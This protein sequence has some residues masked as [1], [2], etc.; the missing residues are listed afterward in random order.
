MT[1]SKYQ[2]LALTAFPAAILHG[3]SE[4][5]DGD[6]PDNTPPTEPANVCCVVVVDDSLG[7]GNERNILRCADGVDVT[8]A[9]APS[10]CDDITLE[11]VD[12]S[13]RQILRRFDLEDGLK[14]EDIDEIVIEA[15]LTDA[16]G[17]YY[18]TD[19][20]LFEVIKDFFEHVQV[21]KLEEC[22]LNALPATAWLPASVVNLHLGKNALTEVALVG[23]ALHNLSVLEL[24]DQEGK[25]TGEEEGAKEED[26]GLRSLALSGFAGVSQSEV[27]LTSVDVSGNSIPN[28]AALDFGEAYIVGLDVRNQEDFDNC[29]V[30]EEDDVGDHVVAIPGAA[31]LESLNM[32]E[33]GQ[34]ANLPLYDCEFDADIGGPDEIELLVWVDTVVVAE[35]CIAVLMCCTYDAAEDAVACGGNAVATELA[36]PACANIDANVVL[37]SLGQVTGN[38]WLGS[39]DIDAKLTI[40]AD[41]S[42]ANNDPIVLTG[43]AS[44]IS[45]L[46]ALVTVDMSGCQLQELAPLPFPST[47]T[48]IDLSGNNFINLEDAIPT[49]QEDGDL[50]AIAL[51]LDTQVTAMEICDIDTLN[52]ENAAFATLRALSICGNSD[53]TDFKCDAVDNLE[54]LDLI[55]DVPASPVCLPTTVA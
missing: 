3:C 16:S 25:F 36:N 37:Y 32:C 5:D 42:V 43:V 1:M 50:S 12:A 24:Q 33:N 45:A 7:E 30:I 14:K 46:P 40:K 11:D 41:L 38:A 34:D 19:N 29:S 53:D 20:N 52:G 27:K 39:A 35:E 10:K 54:V 4:E 15:D 55:T 9:G 48:S 51:N 47:V 22:K 13:M 8:D 44:F 6:D 49:P 31:T 18:L 2:I 23:T 17:N 28:F 21:L 26:S